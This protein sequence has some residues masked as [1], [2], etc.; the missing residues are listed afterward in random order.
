LLRDVAEKAVTSWPW[1]PAFK[2]YFDSEN[3]IRR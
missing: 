1:R 2:P 3:S